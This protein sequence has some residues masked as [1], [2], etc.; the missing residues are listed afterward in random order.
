MTRETPHTT[1]AQ[2]VYDV[3]SS[4]FAS[5]IR[6]DTLDG[7]RVAMLGLPD[8]LGVRMNGGRGGAREGP[9]AFRQALA[10]YGAAAPALA[11]VGTWPAVADAG[12]VEAAGDDLEETHRR[13]RAA[14][15]S[16]AER[17][18]IPIGIGGGHDLTLPLVLGVA[19]ALGRALDGVYFD[20]HLDVRDETGSGMP[21]RRLLEDRKSVV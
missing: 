5:L 8:D 15:R 17:G 16:I 21:F 14:S 6:T 20:A 18:I 1:A 13:V 9:T 19:D 4:R 11:T 12:D 2:P 7:A 3:A 10:R